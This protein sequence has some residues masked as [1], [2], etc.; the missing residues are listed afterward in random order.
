MYFT[1]DMHRFDGAATQDLGRKKYPN[2]FLSVGWHCK[3]KAV[4]RARNKRTLMWAKVFYAVVSVAHFLKENKVCLN[5]L[6][7]F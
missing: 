3:R 4:N 1:K 7:I 6:K 5:Y 2:V